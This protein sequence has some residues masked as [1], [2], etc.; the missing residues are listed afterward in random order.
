MPAVGTTVTNLGMSPATAGTATGLNVGSG[1]RLAR[2]K[3]ISYRV[4][5]AADDGGGELAE[6]RRRN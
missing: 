6:Q 3:R 4:T 2:M 1:T 5:T